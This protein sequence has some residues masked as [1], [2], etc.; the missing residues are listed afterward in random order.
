MA[1]CSTLGQAIGTAMDYCNKNGIL[2][3]ELGNSSEHI[4]KL[5]QI[6]LK[7]DQALLGVKNEDAADLARTAKITASSETADGKAIK[8]ID[9]YNREVGDGIT[10]KWCASMENGEQ[11]IMLSWKKPVKINKI[12]FIFDTGL[13]RFL[14]LSAQD[15]VNDNQIRG[16]Q[17]ETV[18]DYVI[19]VQGK[20]IDKTLLSNENNYLRLVEHS[21]E[22]VEIKQLKIKVTRTNGDPLAKIF[23]VRCYQE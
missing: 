12:Q 16:Q 14:R 18:A 3:T 21:F 13:D 4:I 19:E 2:P 22:S 20:N 1:T 9:G 11:W 7:Q 6:L 10:H 15:W 5:Q 23:E 17:P 8:I